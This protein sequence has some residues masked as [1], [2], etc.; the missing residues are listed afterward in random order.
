MGENSLSQLG[1]MVC[2]N[3]HKQ[4]GLC[5]SQLFCFIEHAGKNIEVRK[6]ERKRGSEREAGTQLYEEKLQEIGCEWFWP[7]GS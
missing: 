6:R 5:E 4:Y 3:T 2:S 7:G 1:P